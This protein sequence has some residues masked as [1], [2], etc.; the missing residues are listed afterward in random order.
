M[1]MPKYKSIPTQYQGVNFRSKLEATWA[2]FFDLNKISWKYE[3]V[4]CEGWIPD[5]MIKTSS[6][7]YFV[8]VKPIW[9]NTIGGVDKKD[10]T[11]LP[12]VFEKCHDA[13]LCL[14]IGPCGHY[15]NV[16]GLR[17]NLIGYQKFIC[18]DA[19]RTIEKFFPIGF[20]HPFVFSLVS[21]FPSLE[22]I[23]LMD[24]WKEA[25]NITQWKSVAQKIPE[26][27]KFFSPIQA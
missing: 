24:R 19:Y 21:D 20:Y 12:D 15:N 4:E 22:P 26:R 27:S 11:Q 10:Q 8:E 18:R 3:P 7:T 17:S 13:A 1:D 23:C 5:F 16:S 25:Q 14:G 6:Q 9:L 2:A